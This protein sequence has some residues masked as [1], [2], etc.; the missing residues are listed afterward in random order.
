[1]A[2]FLLLNNEIMNVLKYVTS[3]TDQQWKAK[4]YNF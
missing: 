2:L 1:M 3:T 4:K